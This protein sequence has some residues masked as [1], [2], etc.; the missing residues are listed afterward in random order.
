MPNIGVTPNV[1]TRMK[2]FMFYVADIVLVIVWLGTAMII[3]NFVFP[4]NRALAN[5][6]YQFI[7]LVFAIWLVITPYHNPGKKNY[8]LIMSDVLMG[9]HHYQ[10]YSYYEFDTLSD[11][12]EIG[13]LK[14]NALQKQASK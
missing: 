11:L 1:K 13:G 14:Q 7:N 4:P 8:E 12:S 6:S 2:I 3:A 5:Y 9:G 10:S